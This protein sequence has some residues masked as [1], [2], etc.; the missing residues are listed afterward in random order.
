VIK[1]GWMTMALESHPDKGGSAEAFRAVRAAWNALQSLYR[2]K[3]CAAARIL[4]R[5]FAVLRSNSKTR[6]TSAHRPPLL[7]L[8]AG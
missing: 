3:K 6:L 7:A 2:S 8:Y 4:R 1:K 5:F